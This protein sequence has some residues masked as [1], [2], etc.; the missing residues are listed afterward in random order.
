MFLSSTSETSGTYFHVSLID[1]T[2]RIFSTTARN[3]THVSPVTPNSLWDLNARCL[4][5]GAISAAASVENKMLAHQHLDCD[6]V[7][8]K[9]CRT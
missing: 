6:V 1:G 5:D 9:K 4:T 2:A 3:R 8:F 7:H